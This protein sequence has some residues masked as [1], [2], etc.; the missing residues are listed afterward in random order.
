[1]CVLPTECIMTLKKHGMK[2]IYENSKMCFLSLQSII[3]YYASQVH[4]SHSCKQENSDFT[5]G[6]TPSV[7]EPETLSWKGRAS[8][9]GGRRG[10]YPGPGTENFNI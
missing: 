1:M 9:R 8:E 7:G 4:F 6:C 2:Y 3:G 5:I 10:S